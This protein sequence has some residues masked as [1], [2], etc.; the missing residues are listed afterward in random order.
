MKHTYRRWAMSLAAI[1]AL[2]LLSGCGGGSGDESPRDTSP[3]DSGTAQ[4]TQSSSGGGETDGPPA[5]PDPARILK[6]AQVKET[7]GVE[8]QIGDGVYVFSQYTYD[9][10]G[11]GDLADSS[12]FLAYQMLAQAD[13]LTLERLS[14]DGTYSEYAIL[15]DEYLLGYLTTDHGQWDLYV[16]DSAD[17]N[18]TSNSESGGSSQSG[19]SQGGLSGGFQNDSFGI[20]VSPGEA[21]PGSSGSAML[22]ESCNGSGRC[23]ACG[24]DG[25]ADNI[26]FGERNAYVCGVCDGTG[27]CPVCDGTGMWVFD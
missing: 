9:F 14:G 8:L 5:V 3:A 19:A 12:D 4:T 13:G 15:W 23:D 20:T 27:V 2:S 25:L 21:D 7:S 1:L 10:S 17:L 16:P 11:S 6:Q 18:S 22:C 26:Y 24:G